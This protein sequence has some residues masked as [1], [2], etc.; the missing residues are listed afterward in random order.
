MST[1][2]G[3]VREQ[4]CQCAVP[5]SSHLDYI[6]EHGGYRT[7]ATDFSGTISCF[8]I[9]SELR[10][11]F[12]SACSRCSMKPG[13]TARTAWIGR[14]CAGTSSQVQLQRSGEDGERAK[15]HVPATVSSPSND[16]GSPLAAWQ[17]LPARDGYPTGR[18]GARRCQLTATS[19]RERHG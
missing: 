5:D 12:I 16:H 15:A 14:A 13:G 4:V 8:I 7:T 3:P 2:T 9:W 11:H 1:S 17:H 18:T 10:Q 19:A 6:E